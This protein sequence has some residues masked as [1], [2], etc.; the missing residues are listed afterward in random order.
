MPAK[1]TCKWKEAN[2]LERG[3]EAHRLATLHKAAI[4][5]R[6]PAGCADGLEADLALLGASAVERG[7]AATRKKGR[8]G[9]KLD[10]AAAGKDFV[11]TTRNAAKRTPGIGAGVLKSLGVGED[12]SKKSDK[13]VA[14]AMKAI[15]DELGENPALVQT[16]GML[17]SDLDDARKIQEKL[18]G[19]AK[20]QQE[21]GV[22]S[23]QKKL[24]RD[25]V[26]RRIED[27]VDL[28]SSRGAL[29]FRAGDQVVRQQ[30]DALVSRS[31]TPPAK[32]EPKPPVGEPAPVA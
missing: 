14:K 28:I 23:K 7:A 18:A 5:E 8:T 30:F 10:A 21:A 22:E 12:V 20:A 1:T 4:E 6:L 19:A 17:Q 15:L 31:W 25:A 16:L 26:Q 2:A 29:A 13:A 3:K 24:D 32:A 9:A 11:S 27:A